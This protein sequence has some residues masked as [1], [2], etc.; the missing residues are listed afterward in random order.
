MYTDVYEVLVVACCRQDVHRAYGCCLLL[1]SIQVGPCNVSVSPVSVSP[2]ALSSH[3]I[4]SL[5]V[6]VL[7][8]VMDQ[9]RHSN[10]K[11]PMLPCISE[12]NLMIF[13]INSQ[14]QC[15]GAYQ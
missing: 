11:L 12:C 6:H 10:L 7:V 1:S 8:G 3:Q 4:E 2:G 13:D 5:Q 15:N 9:E 14:Y